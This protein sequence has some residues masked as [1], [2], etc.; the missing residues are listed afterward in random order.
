[1]GADMFE[2][3]TDRARR[4]VVLAQQEARLLNHNYIGTEHLLLG[5]LAVGEG[6]AVH[7]LDEMGITLEIVRR[8]VVQ[9]VGLG[10]QE[11]RPS[12]HI[13]FTPR[14]K[15]VLELSL[16]EALQMGQNYI[17]TE[18]I[19]LGLIREGDG[20]AAHVLSELGGDLSA[21]RMNFV[22]LVALAGE[23]PEAAD[24]EEPRKFAGPPGLLAML[25]D[26]S[27]RLE[28]IEEHLGIVR[29]SRADPEIPIE[30]AGRAEAGPRAAVG[31]SVAGSGAP[32][33]SAGAEGSR[34]DPATESAGAGGS[35]SD[36]ATESAGAG[37]GGSR[38]EPAT[39]SAEDPG[40]DMAT[41]SES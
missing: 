17:G 16:R 27:A 7:A 3:F 9:I 29:T 30:R 20:V 6:M 23:D 5:I 4:V 37:A 33:E 19:L 21:V 35:R 1:M 2:R 18:H 15:K 39:E 32:S 40:S 41:D 14:A 36:P 11:H 8:Q 26:I 34:S 24:V 12:G 10:Q 31:E 28:R 13:P 38:S 25:R 22:R